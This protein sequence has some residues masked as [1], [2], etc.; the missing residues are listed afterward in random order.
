MKRQRKKEKLA[1]EVYIKKP[2]EDKKQ[3]KMLQLTKN[4]LFA[5]ALAKPDIENVNERRES[6]TRM[7][8]NNVTKVSASEI[9]PTE[10]KILED[11]KK[12]MAVTSNTRSERFLSINVKHKFNNTPKESS[13]KFASEKIVVIHTAV[14]KLV[15][16]SNP[17]YDSTCSAAVDKRIA[18]S[19]I[20]GHQSEEELHV[21]SDVLNKK[22]KKLGV[23]ICMTAINVD[24]E[25]RI[26]SAKSSGSHD[27]MNQEF[28]HFKPIKA[29]PRTPFKILGGKQLEPKLI[30]VIPLLK[31]MSKVV[32][33]PPVPTHSKKVFG[34]ALSAFKRI[35]GQWALTDFL[36]Q[37]E[38]KKIEHHKV[39]RLSSRAIKKI[40][41]KECIKIDISNALSCDSNE[42]CT[43][44]PCSKIVN[45][46]VCNKK[47]N[48]VYNKAKQTINLGNNRR[49]GLIPSAIENKKTEL[50]KDVEVV[51]IDHEDNDDHVN[52][53][54]LDNSDWQHIPDPLGPSL[55]K[56]DLP[57][58]RSR[59]VFEFAAV[60]NI[61]ERIK[62]RKAAS[63]DNVRNTVYKVKAEE[64]ITSKKSSA[65]GCQLKAQ[66][67][68]I[69][70]DKPF[71]KR[72]KNT[73][74]TTVSSKTIKRL[75]RIKKLSKRLRYNGASESTE[76]PAVKQMTPE[77]VLESESS[78]TVRCKPTERTKTLEMGTINVMLS[79]PLPRKRPRK[80]AYPSK[81]QKSL[82]L[83]LSSSELRIDHKNFFLIKEQERYKRL[84][85][86]ECK[87]RELAEQLQARFNAMEQVAGRTRREEGICRPPDN[88]GVQPAKKYVYQEKITW[89]N[90]WM[91]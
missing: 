9:I 6:S 69:K 78:R 73:F 25:E 53:D 67:L 50:R 79:N 24:D 85:E 80:N 89:S 4:H 5:K 76:V 71:T 77:P 2:Q 12:N 55:N 48:T 15:N 26:G 21:P 35:V 66:K 17:L 41:M 68:D 83:V 19:K 63:I 61:A 90:E 38:T 59:P 60:E 42:N 82:A 57:S 28:H 52:V 18:S 7:K 64:E 34:C 44:N 70:L 10:L 75:A 13:K 51:Q 32:P 39:E 29:L 20:Y 47:D 45:G 43:K 30:R 58:E 31:K 74:E 33:N 37:Q 56:F 27:S 72:G 86:Q 84:A 40:E 11:K 87:D 8:L 62:R 54:L 1:S 49:N 22:K 88:K 36:R 65:R 81:K 46:T 23:E 14:T 16:K 3:K 91:D